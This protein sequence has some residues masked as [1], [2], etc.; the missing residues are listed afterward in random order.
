LIN[1]NKIVGVDIIPHYKVIDITFLLSALISFGIIFLNFDIKK[2]K[3]KRYDKIKEEWLYIRFKNRK[4]VSNLYTLHFYSCNFY[5][6]FVAFDNRILSSASFS[7][8]SKSSDLSLYII[9]KT[10]FYYLPTPVYHPIKAIKYPK[11]LRR[12]DLAC[13]LI[14]GSNLKVDSYCS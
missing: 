8:V 6:S 14:S 13:I 5:K 10:K 1:I 12:N 7:R 2:R 11:F 3:Y 4:K 9:N